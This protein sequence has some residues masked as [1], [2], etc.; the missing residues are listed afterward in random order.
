MAALHIHS[1]HHPPRIHQDS[2]E[3]ALRL[4]MVLW[5]T[6]TAKYLPSLVDRI[7]DLPPH[8]ARS[9]EHYGLQNIYHT[10]LKF[11]D[12]AYLAKFMTSGHPIAEGTSSKYTTLASSSTLCLNKVGSGFRWSWRSALWNTVPFGL[13]ETKHGLS[14]MTFMTFMKGVSI[15]LFLHL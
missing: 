13:I 2:G 9:V 3:A 12:I 14:I 4:Q 15:R 6:F 11:V 1:Q 10:A 5:A 7:L 8:S